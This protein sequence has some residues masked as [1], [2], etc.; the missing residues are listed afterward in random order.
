MFS[1]EFI[2]RF[3]DR[4][5]APYAMLAAAGA[6]SYV[7]AVAFV[8]CLFDV[9]LRRAPKRFFI[10]FGTAAT[11]AITGLAV[12]DG[13]TAHSFS[14]FTAVCIP[15]AS[16]LLFLFEYAVLFAESKMFV[17]TRVAPPEGSESRGRN[18]NAQSAPDSVPR[19]VPDSARG[20]AGR[21]TSHGCYFAPSAPSS[22][23]DS[24]AAA[25]A[26]NPVK[27]EK[28]AAICEIPIRKTRLVG[29]DGAG[30]GEV[31]GEKYLKEC[32]ARLK[33]FP[34]TPDDRVALGRIE[35]EL[36]FP[37]RAETAEEK[38]RLGENCGRIINMLAA[39]AV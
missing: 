9:E 5:L 13:M 36:T 21:E 6:A 15:F 27:C 14:D 33:A 37:I 18:E 4:G 29:M 2:K 11:V 19:S 17:K 34:L 1:F 31:F 35:R 26:Q 28:K 30:G 7:F 10:W 16:A 25:P 8:A 38:R 20:D 3:F 39:Y 22:P 24:S 23:R 12:L 32:I